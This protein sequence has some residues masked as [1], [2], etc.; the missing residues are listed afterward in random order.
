MR[1]EKLGGTEERLYQ[2]VAPL[3]MKPSVLRQNNNYPFKTSAH[4]VWFVALE[5]DEVA[6]F[7]PVE[8]KG[9]SVVINNYH[10]T[11]EDQEILASML[12]EV[13]RNFAGECKLQSI[14]HTRHM[15]VFQ[16]SGFYVTRTW[17][18]YVKMEYRRI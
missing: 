16:E 11:G 9:Q 1:I 6:G 13:V 7:V 12:Q 17:K 8:V 18:L 10:I 5:G 15:S 4:H 2:L 14:T 3:V